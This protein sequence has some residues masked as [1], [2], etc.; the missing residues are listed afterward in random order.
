MKPIYILK[1]DLYFQYVLVAVNLCLA[2]YAFVE[3]WSLILMLYL[4]FFINLYHFFTNFFH[5]K[6]R[7]L[8]PWF[9]KCRN[10][11]KDLTLYYVPSAILVTAFIDLYI[12][13]GISENAL[14]VIMLIIWLIIP[15][16]V[17][18]L[19]IYLYAR[20]VNFIEQNEFHILK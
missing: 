20:E 15:Q 16:I 17:L 12:K 7:C 5:L 1:A 10:A 3:I 4:Q 19:Y 18:H 11:Y 13:M 2:V 8:H 6:S 14:R 9:T